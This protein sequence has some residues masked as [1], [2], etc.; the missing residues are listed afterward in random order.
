M[1][2]RRRAPGRDTIASTLAASVASSRGPCCSPCRM[3]K[4][5]QL[6]EKIVKHLHRSVLRRFALSSRRSTQRLSRHGWTARRLCSM[7]VPARCMEPS[8]FT[9]KAYGRSSSGSVPCAPFVAAVLPVISSAVLLARLWPGSRHRCVRASHAG[10]RT[11]HGMVYPA[12][13]CSRSLG[14][15]AL[16][17]FVL[18]CHRDPR[19]HALMCQLRRFWSCLFCRTASSRNLI[20]WRCFETYPRFHGVIG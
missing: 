13:A 9:S 12:K 10:W 4:H 6:L 16:A 1:H 15:A 5:E 8:E 14:K 7:S 19:M 17:L 18:G 3:R 2:I 11:C 20:S